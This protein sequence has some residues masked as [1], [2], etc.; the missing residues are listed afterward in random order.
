[1]SV[2]GTVVVC[3][4]QKQSF[5]R[6]STSLHLFPSSDMFFFFFSSVIDVCS[7]ALVI[8]LALGHTCTQVYAETAFFLVLETWH[9]DSFSWYANVVVSFYVTNFSLVW[10]RQEIQDT[11]AL[12]FKMSRLA[13]F[14]ESNIH[15]DS[16]VFGLSYAQKDHATNGAILLIYLVSNTENQQSTIR[17][18]MNTI[19]PASFTICK[20]SQYIHST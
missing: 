5:M 2:R 17:N 11:K 4:K 13:N 18:C 20:H 14:S 12:K 19:S 8:T 7:W 15:L 3:W 10:S 9:I 1:M 6:L 16:S